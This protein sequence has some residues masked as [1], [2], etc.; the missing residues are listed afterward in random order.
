MIEG[1][2]SL[3]KYAMRFGT[4]MGVYWIFK[5]I[6]LVLGF[7][8]HFLGLAFMF[9]TL[10]V[11]FMGYYYLRMVRDRLLGGYIGF[12]HA[13]AFTMAI[14]VFAGILAA[15]AH[16]VYFQYIDQGRVLELYTTYVNAMKSMNM[17]GTEDSILVLEENIPL[18][19][20]LTSLDWTFQLFNMNVFY[21]AIFA[22]ITA[23]FGMRRMPNQYP[24][25][26]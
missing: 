6:L 5:F 15:V 25:A 21:G 20:G 9:L 3:Y 7:D 14:Y 17:P 12:I 22:G 10:A 19:E 1:R 23:L 18:L 4:I 24:P 13:W 16:Y 2:V 26:P 8:Y 11:P